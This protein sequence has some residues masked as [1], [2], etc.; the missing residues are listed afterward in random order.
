M[1]WGRVITY[2]YRQLKP[3]E[4]RYLTHDLELG[5][6]VLALKIGD[7]ISMGSDDHIHISRS[8]RCLNDQPNL[9][10]RQRRWLYVS[11][12]MTVR[13]FIIMERTMWLPKY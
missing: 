9:N 12:I 6:V 10:M 7:I 2:A 8:L 11:R 3:Q 4:V 13:F 5:E 1:Q